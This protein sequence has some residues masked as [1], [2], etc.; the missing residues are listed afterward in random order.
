MNKGILNSGNNISFL[1]NT[2]GVAVFKLSKVSIRPLFLV[3]NEL[4]YEKR[5]AK[6]NMMLAGLWFGDKKPA[7]AT[8]LKP[9]YYKLQLLDKGILVQ[10]P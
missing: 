4:P 10:S 9:L 1:F 2:D 5:M 6:E 8:Y 7:M 3:I